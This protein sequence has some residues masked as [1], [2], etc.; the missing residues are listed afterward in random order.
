MENGPSAPRKPKRVPLPGQ[1]APRPK[2]DAPFREEPELFGKGD[3]Q[4]RALEKKLLKQLCQDPP[5]AA[6]NLPGGTILTTQGTPHASSIGGDGSLVTSLTTRLTQ[7]E[8]TVRLQ[9][10]QL[11]KKDTTI[12]ELRKKNDSQQVEIS[13]LKSETTMLLKKIADMEQFL[14]DYGLEWRGPVN[15]DLHLADFSRDDGDV[16]EDY[17]KWVQTLQD[18]P[19]QDP[20]E[21]NP[22]TFTFDIGKIMSN[23]EELNVLAGEGTSQFQESKDGSYQLRRVEPLFL[24]IY[25]NGIRIND[26]PFRCFQDDPTSR[27]FVK[28]LVDGYFP[29][30][31]KEK[32]PDGVPFKVRNFVTSDYEPP[33]K[34]FLG[35]GLKLG[36]PSQ[37]AAKVWKPAASTTPAP[38]I[39]STEDSEK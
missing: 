18:T 37:D 14:A 28:D 19:P 27:S 38:P 23:V 3:D 25:R 7:V 32:Y 4:D 24:S 6:S 36:D 30:E 11:Q 31:L 35:Q 34:S 17:K 33:Q 2:P 13:R 16:D 1:I 39:R 22:D 20:N 9:K 8:K 21:S 5:P 26:G 29:Y 10:E 15:S 12:T